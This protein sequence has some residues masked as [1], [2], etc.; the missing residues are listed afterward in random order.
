MELNLDRIRTANEAFAADPP[1]A[2]EG[3][4]SSRLTILTCMDTRIDPYR[5]FGLSAGEA[6]ILRNAG[7]R[8]T[9]DA[10][11]SIALSMH[12]LGTREIGVI[13]HTRCGLHG[14]SNADIAAKIAEGGG[15]DASHI[16]FL[17][18]DDL[19]QSVADDLAALRGSGLLP[20]DAVL[21]G[22][23]YDVDSGVLRITDEP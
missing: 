7:G 18:F 14:G 3:R 16:D 22:G 12:V 19:D 23:V 4:P 9:D 6:H 17:P 1:P 20:A 2:R 10:V 8:A 11:R 13:H 5:A 15:A 21:W